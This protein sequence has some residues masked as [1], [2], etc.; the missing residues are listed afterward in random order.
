MYKQVIHI[1]FSSFISDA[2]SNGG[3]SNGLQNRLQNLTIHEPSSN[4]ASSSCNFVPT[5]SQ[6]R[7]NHFGTIG[8]LQQNNNYQNEEFQNS[9]K[10]GKS[11][12]TTEATSLANVS[13]PN[14][15]GSNPLI[16]STSPQH[17]YSN[18]IHNP[19][20]SNPK[21]ASG[22][23]S[24][25]SSRTQSS[26]GSPDLEHDPNLFNQP[27]TIPPPPIP[28][29]QII[30][31]EQQQQLE[32]VR[33]SKLADVHDLIHLPQPI[34]E[35]LVLRALQARFFN[36]NYFTNVGPIVLSVNSYNNVGNPLTLE[37]TKDASDN[38]P[39]LRKVAEEAIRL[40]TESGYP[41]T[42]IVS[43]ISGSGK[44]HASMILLR[45]LFSLAEGSQSKNLESDTFKHLSATF[46]VLRSM[47]S[48]QTATNKESS[49]IGHFI[50]VQVTDNILNKTK[51]HCYYLDQ[52]RVV[53]PPPTEKSYHIFYQMMAGLHPDERL[54]LGLN[55]YTV[56]DLNYLNM[57]DIRQDEM[58]DAERFEQWRSALAILG[59]PFMDV[60]RVLSAILLLGNVRFTPRVDRDDFDVEVIGREELHSVAKLLGVSTTLLCQGL[61]MRTH[62][63]RGQAMKSMNDSHQVI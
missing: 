19:G 58:E 16:R 53:K 44:T 10:S 15:A 1:H 62:A 27:P 39:E 4:F 57:G 11:H 35:D 41:Q 12:V 63:V 46:T 51:I 28:T 30:R 5:Q 61:T 49:R 38:C 24:L 7:Y 43:G 54:Q 60:V 40:Q 18:I 50:E 42:I 36:R 45:Q 55:S 2:T 32:E 59:I 33:K 37:S 23:G 13:D 14:S 31:R 17:N 6:S 29:E 22:G 25:T 26:N 48:A 8:S 34:T 52:G 20:A 9:L 3:E 47:G 56:R 21:T